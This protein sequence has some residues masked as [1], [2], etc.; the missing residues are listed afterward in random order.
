MKSVGIGVS[1][2]KRRCIE[3]HGRR[4]GKRQVHGGRIRV[5][6]TPGD[7]P[8]S[9]ASVAVPVMAIEPNATDP[10]LLVLEFN[11]V[12]VRFSSVRPPL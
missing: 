3:V 4:T 6:D 2:I 11:T 1:R 12:N 9:G 10:A 8:A 5:T 7:V